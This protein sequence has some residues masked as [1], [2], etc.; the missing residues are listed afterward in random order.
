MKTPQSRSGTSLRY[1]PGSPPAQPHR[2]AMEGLVSVLSVLC[3]AVGG[4]VLLADDTVIRN[5]QVLTMLDGPEYRQ[6]DLVVRD[7]V[8]ANEA[9]AADAAVID[10][11]GKFVIPGLTE[12]HAHVPVVRFDQG[13]ERYREDVLFLWV[14][15]GVTLARGMMGHPSHLELRE[16]LEANEVLG[17]RLITS[18]PSFSGRDRTVDGASSRVREQRA[19]G[20]DL[21]KIHPG[22]PAEVFHSVASTAND[23]GIEFSGHVTGS[24]GL[25]ASLEA[26]QRTIDHLDG[27]VET[28]VE[29]ERLSNRN[30]SWFGADLAYEADET[31]IEAT[32]DALL[33]SGAALV[34]TETLL[35][36]VAGSLTELQSRDEYDYLPPNLRTG[37]SN[38]V[39]GSANA[40]T[41]DSAKTF[42]D[43]R[44]RLIGAAFRAGVPV[45]L[46]S[47]SPQIF[48]VP[49][50]SIHHE[51]EAMAEAGL[52]PFEALVT[53]TTAPAEF[54]GQDHRWGS[55]APGRS[56][57]LIVLRDDPL[58]DIANTRSI[59]AVMVRGRYLS[60]EELDAGLADIRERY[61]S[62][63]DDA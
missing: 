11:A 4:Q 9:A 42:L 57:D 44:K 7:G 24:V 37:Y 60:R 40:F 14:A 17:P 29:S 41:A 31:R 30:P 16:A 15:N 48:N 46:G 6:M 52:S 18:G 54:Y 5:A 12:M 19:A 1:V 27:F 51:L 20:Y 33:E 32:L 49:G 10:A 28:L 45:L 58:A 61:R 38:A 39:R 3:I 50:F 47:D 43:L 13:G 34:P 25:I 55:I 63:P 23:E 62:P 8:F 35:E 56:A 26:G 2:P 21:L 53:G 22:L 36:N 59:D